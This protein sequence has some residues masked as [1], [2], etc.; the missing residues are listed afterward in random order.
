MHR[1]GTGRVVFDQTEP[2]AK[3]KRGDSPERDSGEAGRLKT[4]R[5]EAGRNGAIPTRQASRP[6]IRFGVGL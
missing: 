5:H 4:K 1:R 3:P 2:K 6:T